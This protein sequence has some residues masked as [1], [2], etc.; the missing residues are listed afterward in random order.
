MCACVW[1]YEVNKWVFN[2]NMRSIKWIE[3]IYAARLYVI[4]ADLLFYTYCEYRSNILLFFYLLW[5][6]INKW[7]PA[8]LMRM[9][10]NTPRMADHVD[11]EIV[12]K[13]I[14]SKRTNNIKWTTIY[15]VTM[16]VWDV[17]KCPRGKFTIYI[18]VVMMMMGHI[19][20]WASEF[21]CHRCRR[22]SS[23][24]IRSC[25]AL[26]RFDCDVHESNET[27]THERRQRRKKKEK[28]KWA[29][30]NKQFICYPHLSFSQSFNHVD[31]AWVAVWIY[32]PDDIMLSMPPPIFQRFIVMPIPIPYSLASEWMR[33]WMYGFFRVSLCAFS[34][35]DSI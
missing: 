26:M 22:L 30:Q 32:M 2:Q 16:N 21:L 10:N 35:F 3:S 34:F 15:I 31:C 24:F 27:R 6:S 11:W 28:K 7:I 25:V 17:H 12:M 1:V 19:H 33:S 4:V 13:I 14:N 20:G 9:R 23:P 18:I 8:M 5:H 29:L